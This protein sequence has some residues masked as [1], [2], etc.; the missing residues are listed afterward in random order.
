MARAAKETEAGPKGATVSTLN[1]EGT[2]EKPQGPRKIVLGVLPDEGSR[3]N[4]PS[5]AEAAAVAAAAAGLPGKGAAVIVCVEDPAHAL[6]LAAAV[7]RSLPR[8]SAPDGQAGASRAPWP[9]P[10]PRPQGRSCR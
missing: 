7:G 6:P 9:S 8:Y 1:P 4:A 2:P 3:H 5:R 10:P